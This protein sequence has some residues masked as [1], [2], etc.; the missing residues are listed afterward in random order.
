M[1][2]NRG[3]ALIEHELE[4]VVV[5]ADGEVAPLEVR[6][7]VAHG[8]DEPDQL[9]FVGSE[10]VMTCR[11]RVTEE[12]EGVVPLVKHRPEPRD[13]C[14]T[15]HQERFVEVREL[16]NRGSGKRPL[17]RVERRGGLW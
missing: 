16:K 17:E 2:R 14:I 8:Q 10:F 4:G 12:H 7:P 3:Q 5:Y 6:P 9:V 1:L 11:E 13:G 15:V